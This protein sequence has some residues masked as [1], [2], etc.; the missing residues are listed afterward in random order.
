MMISE[1]AAFAGGQA[2]YLQQIEDAVSQAGDF[3]LIKAV[4]YFD[5]PG[6]DGNNTYPLDSAGWQLF[7]GLSAERGVPTCTIDLDGRGH[8]VSGLNG[9]RTPCSPQRPSVEHRLWGI[10]EL[11]GQRKPI[12]GMSVHSTR[13]RDV[14][15]HGSSSRGNQP[16]LGGLQRRRRGRRGH[17]NRCQQGGL[18]PVRTHSFWLRFDFRCGPGSGSFHSQFA[19]LPFLGLPDFGGVASTGGARRAGTLFAFPLTLG[20]PDFASPSNKGSGS[21]LDPIEWTKTLLRGG[22]GATAV[23]VPAAAVILLLLVTYMV[24]TWTQD[25]RRAK[26]VLPALAGNAPPDR[27]PRSSKPEEPE[28]QVHLP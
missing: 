21:N 20:L 8:G 24:S 1:T 12:S 28:E 2:S 5:A 14:V 25:R 23:L 7:Q 27:E 22:A 3:P 17:G 13:R 9:R 11:R 18:G 10:C 15:L 16:D 6:N 4:M 19:F 26:R